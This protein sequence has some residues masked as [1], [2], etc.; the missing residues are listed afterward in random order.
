MWLWKYLCSLQRNPPLLAVASRKIVSLMNALVMGEIEVKLMYFNRMKHSLTSE[1]CMHNLTWE[2]NSLASPCSLSY[3]V[4]ASI[5]GVLVARRGLDRNAWWRKGEETLAGR[6]NVS[7]LAAH[8]VHNEGFVVQSAAVWT[9][10]VGC[11]C[12][13]WADI[14]RALNTGGVEKVGAHLLCISI[15][16]FPKWCAAVHC[17]CLILSHS[18]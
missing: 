4:V 6:G 15:P 17:H 7:W 10:G 9:W 8:L 13:Y 11:E 12:V 3:H 18:I 5:K 16:L 14:W 2:T 1:S